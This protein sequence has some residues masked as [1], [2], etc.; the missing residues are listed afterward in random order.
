MRWSTISKIFLLIGGISLSILTLTVVLTRTIASKY[1]AVVT[2]P[3][4]I[5]AF[6]TGDEASIQ[7]VRYQHHLEYQKVER[8]K[9]VFSTSNDLPQPQIIPTTI[10][11][12]SGVLP[13]TISQSLTQLAPARVLHRGRL[14]VVIPFFPDAIATSGYIVYAKVLL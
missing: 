14:Y 2:D 1:H 8:G 7:T 9:I 10:T 6:T 4:V 3:R 11:L 5:T 12:I 13:D